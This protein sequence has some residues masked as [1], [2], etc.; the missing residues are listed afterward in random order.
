MK[1]VK[2]I[3][4]VI[5][6]YGA[7]LVRYPSGDLKR[8]MLLLKAHNITLL[9]DVGANR[10]SY[11]EELFKLKYTGRIVSFEPLS[12]IFGSLLSKSK[13][14]SSWIAE[15]YALGDFDGSLEINVAGNIDSSSIL[16]MLP[17]HL[18]SA[19]ASEYIGKETIK[20]RKLDS[21]F[22]DFYK[23]TDNVF[24]KIDTQGYEMSVLKG[25]IESIPFIKGIQIEL[26]L[27][28]LYEG[29]V[30]MFEMI[31]FIEKMGFELTSLEN[32]FSNPKTG[33]L[34]QCDGIFF[35]K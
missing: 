22:K 26:S 12:N 30:L 7:E 29:S 25:A 27:E 32:G 11:S 21:V 3:N 16:Q 19:P 13:K 6:N 20:V 15:Q 1:L 17:K 9:L 2:T 31:D 14:H 33:K 35:R 28:Q 4:K 8:R 34:L 10:G 18:E 5:R 23:E 24:L